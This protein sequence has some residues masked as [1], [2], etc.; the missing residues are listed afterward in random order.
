M[1]F[2]RKWN[3]EFNSNGKT[4]NCDLYKINWISFF[5]DMQKR[6]FVITAIIL[7]NGIINK[8]NNTVYGNKWD[9]MHGYCLSMLR[10]A[11]KEAF[12]ILFMDNNL[13]SLHLFTSSEVYSL[14]WFQMSL[15]LDK[16]CFEL[17]FRMLNK[18]ITNRKGMKCR[19]GWWIHVTLPNIKR[20]LFPSV[21]QTSQDKCM[22]ERKKFA[23]FFSVQTSTRMPS[24]EFIWNH[25]SRRLK[26][27]NRTDEGNVKTPSKLWHVCS[28]RVVW[29]IFPSNVHVVSS[30]N[31]KFSSSFWLFLCVTGFSTRQRL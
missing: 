28:S 4:S 23:N 11:K 26:P 18:T 29:L 21:C 2:F 13:H 7:N 6:R 30:K 31:G 19:L 12:S 27:T 14:R 17:M 9:E 8:S 24:L 15:F 20:E 3:H 16:S 5:S 1:T 22:F 25:Q 10:G